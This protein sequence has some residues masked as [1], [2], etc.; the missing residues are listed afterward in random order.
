[1]SLVLSIAAYAFLMLGLMVTALGLFAEG[2][3][4]EPSHAA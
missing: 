1:M 4:D 3:E 2:L